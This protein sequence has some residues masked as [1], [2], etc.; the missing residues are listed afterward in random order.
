MKGQNVLFSSASAPVFIVITG[1]AEISEPG[2]HGDRDGARECS[3]AEH[4]VAAWEAVY[5]S[6]LNKVGTFIYIEENGRTF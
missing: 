3:Y 1:E 2:Y 6:T 5:N 4:E